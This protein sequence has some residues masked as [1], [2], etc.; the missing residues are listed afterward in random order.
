MKRGE[1]NTI[2][3]QGT[4]RDTALESAVDDG[5][6]DL[7]GGGV[8]QFHDGG[9]GDVGIFGAGQEPVRVDT[10]EVGIAAFFDGGSCAQADGS[11]NGH[12]D[13]SAFVHQRDCEFAAFLLVIEGH[14]EETGIGV[15]GVPAEDF[16]VGALNFVVLGNALGETIHEDGNGGDGQTAE[17][18]DL[19]GLGHASGEVA[20]QEGGF[21][22]VEDL[23]NDVGDGGVVGV[24]DN[25]EL[26]VRVGFSGGFGGI[27][28]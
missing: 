19:T 2:V 5:F 9:Q 4:N 17:G 7:H 1:R 21:V 28:D 20:S 18:S 12:D 16:H 27:A 8:H 25:G 14:A 6:D 22:G 3:R 24:V 26:D 15:G 11:G 10:D 23:A 13:V